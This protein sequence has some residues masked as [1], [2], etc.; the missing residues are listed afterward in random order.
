MELIRFRFE[1]EPLKRF[2][3]LPALLYGQDPNRFLLPDAGRF[4]NAE[5]PFFSYGEHQN[6]LV[7][8]G[9]KTL[10]RL[11]ASINPRFD[12]KIGFV[13]F[14][15]AV[16]PIASRL[17]LEAGEAWLREKGCREVWGPIDLTI[18]N[19]YRFVTRGH[20]KPVF[21]GEPHNLPTFPALFEQAGF[22]PIKEWIS[23]LGKGELYPLAALIS[24]PSYERANQAGYRFLSS[25]PAEL[26]GN[27]EIIHRLI[28][29]SYRDFLGFSPVEL[30]EFRLLTEGLLP[31]IDPELVLIVTDPHDE[32][33]AFSI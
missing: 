19:G 29:A 23:A 33:T 12:R 27:L 6:F 13:G 21:F 31:V 8:E 28:M 10:G 5:N 4:L 25:N 22:R 7:V 20:A 14:F 2:A 1:E 32:P 24:K 9:E 30:D 15:A 17:L 3:G 11:T 26:E 18:W 16:A